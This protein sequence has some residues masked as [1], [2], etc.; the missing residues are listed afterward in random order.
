MEVRNS[1]YGGSE[2]R[3]QERRA[4][5]GEKNI[6]WDLALDSTG[7]GL[8]GRGQGYRTNSN[9]LPLSKRKREGD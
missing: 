8:E 6:Y 3:R 1:L 9:L 7:G 5:S 2:E 4:G